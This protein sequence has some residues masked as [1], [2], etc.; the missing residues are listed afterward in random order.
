MMLE[1]VRQLTGE[2]VHQ[3]NTG[4]QSKTLQEGHQ[5]NAIEVAIIQDALEITKK[6]NTNVP[7]MA[8]IARWGP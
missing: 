5:S 2:T 6:N 4:K 8:N 1:H 3:F 7:V